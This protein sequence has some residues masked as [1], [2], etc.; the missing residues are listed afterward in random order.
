MCELWRRESRNFTSLFKGFSLLF[1]RVFHTES[2]CTVL[3]RCDDDDFFL[4]LLALSNI[5]LRCGIF[6]I[7]YE[8]LFCRTNKQYEKNRVSVDS[9]FSRFV[10]ARRRLE[11]V[12]SYKIS[13][14]RLDNDNE[15]KCCIIFECIFFL[16]STHRKIAFHI[17]RAAQ[18]ARYHCQ[19]FSSEA[20]SQVA[21]STQ[22]RT[23]LKTLNLQ[24]FTFSEIY[25]SFFIAEF[26]VSFDF[27]CLM[28]LLFEFLWTVKM[29]VCLV[30]WNK[31]LDT[32]ELL[33]FLYFLILSSLRICLLSCGFL[34]M[35][36]WHNS[37]IV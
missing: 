21:I 29:L 24:F 20:L 3:S 9:N 4:L 2:L 27:L 8:L 35:K 28:D 12:F 6:F 26:D 15:K 37:H 18:S 11:N 5:F 32:S 22:H 30:Y 23:S 19:P 25:F 34:H 1:S 17:D 16:S 7:N 31:A 10:V 14:L 36:S 33:Y 13:L